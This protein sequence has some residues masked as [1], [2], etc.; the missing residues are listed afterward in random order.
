M[1]YKAALDLETPNVEQLGRKSSK[2]CRQTNPQH[3]HDPRRQMGNDRLIDIVESSG[4]AR[5]V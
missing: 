2:A 4:A 5:A 1:I 3:H